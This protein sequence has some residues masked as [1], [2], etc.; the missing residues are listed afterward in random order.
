LEHIGKFNDISSADEN[1]LNITI[2]P[3]LK[4]IKGQYIYSSVKE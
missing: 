2:E 1:K 3:Y 4:A